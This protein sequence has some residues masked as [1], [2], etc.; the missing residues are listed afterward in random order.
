MALE[1]KQEIDNLGVFGNYHRIGAFTPLECKP[2]MVPQNE[3]HLYLYVS[4][5]TR[6]KGKT[7]HGA[8]KIILGTDFWNEEVEKGLTRLERLKKETY[9]Y[10]KAKA[11][12]EAEKPKEEQNEELAKWNESIN[13]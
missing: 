6:E 5:E 3:A 13:V 1:L 2:G 4:K 12:M 8:Y 7:P 9:I 11:S 10:L